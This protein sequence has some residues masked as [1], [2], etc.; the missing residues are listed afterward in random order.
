MWTWWIIST[1]GFFVIYSQKQMG[2]LFRT[3]ASF[4]LRIS[5]GM[6]AHH[7]LTLAR[8]LKETPTLLDCSVLLRYLSSASHPISRLLYL[9]NQVGVFKLL[10]HVPLVLHPRWCKTSTNNP[11]AFP[12][13]PIFPRTLYEYLNHFLLLQPTKCGP[14]I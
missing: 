10:V 13:Q 9:A 1:A 8:P 4:A 2:C 11:S 6:P 3:I 7:H 14:Y 5:I 12:L